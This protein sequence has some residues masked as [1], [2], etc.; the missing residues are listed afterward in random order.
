[1]MGYGVQPDAMQ[2]IY[3]HLQSNPI[4][5]P[6]QA[7][8]FIP[9]P[10]P[11]TGGNYSQSAQVLFE[12]VECISVMYPT[13]PTH[14][15]CFKNPNIQNFQLK[16]DNALFPPTPISTNTNLSPEFITYQLN[17]SDLD[18]SIEPTQSWMS[19][20]TEP[21][22]DADGVRYPNTRFDDTDFMLNISTERSQGGY[23]F[24][25]LT[26]VKAVNVELRFSPVVT[27]NNDVY[28]RPDQLNLAS[29]IQVPPE[30]WICRDTY[31][32]LGIGKVVY[33]RDGTPKE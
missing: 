10:A 25:G 7:L 11:T 4:Y 17:A 29:T 24:D 9:Y 21:R 1:M 26:T 33:H 28:Y 32:E 31:F 5:I 22:T 12:N 8:D 23:V 27:G 15:T 13:N 30:L 3:N 2:A 14:I 16:I 6:A 18:G 19:S 20:I